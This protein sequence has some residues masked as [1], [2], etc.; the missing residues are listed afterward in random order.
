MKPYNSFIVS[1][2]QVAK[3]LRSLTFGKSW[4][5]NEKV[6]HRQ[7]IWIIFAIMDTGAKYFRFLM[8]ANS[9]KGT[10]ITAM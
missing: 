4:K 7:I 10:R 3:G 6:M 5:M 2:H 8:A 1:A 9:N